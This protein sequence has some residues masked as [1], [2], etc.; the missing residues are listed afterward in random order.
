MFGRQ[1]R[2]P[3]DVALG[4]VPQQV[5][6]HDQYAANLRQTL[7]EVYQTVPTNLGAHLQR[8]KEIYN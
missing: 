4:T 6:S 7:E 1:A 2:L 8:Q 3:V 5:V